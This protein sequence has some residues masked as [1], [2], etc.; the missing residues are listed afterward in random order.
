MEERENTGVLRLR[1]GQDLDSEGAIAGDP[2]LAQGLLVALE[3]TIA[4]PDAKML[5][6][7][8]KQRRLKFMKIP[9]A[10]GRLRILALP[11]ELPSALPMCAGS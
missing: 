10:T 7:T 1:L 6:K 4:V 5:C 3:K 8:V 11:P 2:L 9:E